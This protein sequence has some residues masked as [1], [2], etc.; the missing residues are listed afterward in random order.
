MIEHDA[1]LKAAL[2]Q[3]P[4][5]E[6]S[7]DLLQRIIRSRAMG[8]RTTLPNGASIV[9][10]RWLAAAAVGTVLIGGSWM[11]SLSLSEIRESRVGARDPFA[12]LLRG[13]R[14]WRSEDSATNS[15]RKALEPKYGLILSSSLDPSRLSEGL[16]TYR[17][18]TTT[19][20]IFTEPSFVGG[21]RIRMARGSY[22]GEPAWVVTT[23]RRTRAQ[24]WGAFADTVYVDAATLRPRY[25]VAYGYKFRTRIV[26]TFSGNR[27]F[28]SITI[29]GPM[30]GFYSGGMELPFPPE[31]V[32]T[33]DWSLREFGVLTPAMPLARAWRGSLYQTGLFARS[34]PGTLKQRAVPLDIRVEGRDRVSVPAGRFDCWRVEVV[35]HRG[36]T[37]RWTMWVAREQGWIVKTEFRG[38][39]YVVNEVLESYEP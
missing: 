14:L 5:P 2:R 25:A 8:V 36:G 26:E 20:G 16:W 3:L 27:G 17:S 23:A 11:L 22:S 38:S 18:T 24:P 9:P 1:K 19:D 37:E 15:P 10:W 13:T 6:P 28:Q 7:P 29:T 34:G 21:T 4:A 12:E 35:S 32:F 33:N 39:D 31:A 30:T